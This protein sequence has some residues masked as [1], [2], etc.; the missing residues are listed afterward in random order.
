MIR[1]K[2]KSD[3]VSYPLIMLQW[4][5]FSL[6]I[7]PKLLNLASLLSLGVQT[8]PGLWMMKS[9]ELIYL[10][11]HWSQSFASKKCSIIIKNYY[12]NFWKQDTW[13]VHFY[14]VSTKSVKWVRVLPHSHIT[15]HR[16]SLE[17]KRSLALRDVESSPSLP[18]QP[19]CTWFP[20]TKLYFSQLAYLLVSE[21][22]SAP[23]W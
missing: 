13:F 6:G 9:N 15:S 11:E 2:C 8:I 10:K 14:V 23:P 4:L 16:A 20:L 22:I 3:G 18:S 12:I 7:K 17:N 21:H 19:S 5:S 1:L